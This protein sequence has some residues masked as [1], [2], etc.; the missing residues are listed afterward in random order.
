M[1]Y[2]VV[3]NSIDGEVYLLIFREN[4]DLLSEQYDMGNELGKFSPKILA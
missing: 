2:S 1:E 4:C 3:I